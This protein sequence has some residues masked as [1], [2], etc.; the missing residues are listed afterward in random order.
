MKNSI[1][2]IERSVDNR[3]SPTQPTPTTKKKKLKYSRV[4]EGWTSEC[5]EEEEEEA[6]AKAMTRRS[7]A[8]LRRIAMAAASPPIAGS[9]GEAGGGELG[10]RGFAGL[11]V[12]AALRLAPF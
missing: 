2:R 7:D 12:F 6:A 3:H 5:K 4:S 1:K 8:R 9:R 11:G 10:F